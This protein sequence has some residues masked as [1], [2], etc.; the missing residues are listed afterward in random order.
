MMRFSVDTLVV[1]CLLKLHRGKD[2]VVLK[3]FI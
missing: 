2:L 1:L 3:V